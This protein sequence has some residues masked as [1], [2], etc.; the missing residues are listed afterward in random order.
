MANMCGTDEKVLVASCQQ[1]EVLRRGAGRFATAPGDRWGKRLWLSLRRRVRGHVLFW[2][3][4]QG[5]QL[6]GDQ[7]V[8]SADVTPA[9][10]EASWA[11]DDGRGFVRKISGLRPL[12]KTSPTYAVKGRRSAAAAASA[13][14]E[15]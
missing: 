11:G 10:V 15:R 13:K 5:R 7:E 14:G 12:S 1:G 6:S 8:S 4:R 2:K 9:L 3:G